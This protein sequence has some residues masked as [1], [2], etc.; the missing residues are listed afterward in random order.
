MIRPRRAAYLVTVGAGWAGYG[1]GIVV[2]PRYGTARGLASITRYVPLDVL[3]WGWVACGLLAVAAG[4]ARGC[5]RWQ[6]AGFTAL[7]VPATVWGAAFTSAWTSGSYPSASG[8]AVAW[9]AMA[10]GVYWVSGMVDPPAK[11]QVM[12]Q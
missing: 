7:A 11:G 10:L 1:A 5:P 4:L 12:R 8:S 3:G 6:S 9:V 2:D